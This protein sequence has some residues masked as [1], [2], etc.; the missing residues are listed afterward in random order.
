MLGSDVDHGLP[1]NAV[2]NLCE[3]ET[4]GCHAKI[5]SNL[6]ESS[7]SNRERTKSTIL[8][9]DIFQKNK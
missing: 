9:L 3:L 2:S 6:C 4:V 7:L 5:V 1:E 8:D